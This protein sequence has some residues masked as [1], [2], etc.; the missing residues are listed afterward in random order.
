MRL[1]PSWGKAYSR[2]GAALDALGCTRD[3]VAA[4]EKGVKHQPD[5]QHMRSELFRLKSKLEPPKPAPASESAAAA[6]DAAIATAAKVCES[7]G[8]SCIPVL[9]ARRGET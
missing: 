2:Q 7:S 4:Y 5:N 3:A 1:R 8:G 6:A 9:Q